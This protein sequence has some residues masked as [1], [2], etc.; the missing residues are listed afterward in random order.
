MSITL[1]KPLCHVKSCSLICILAVE[2]GE[3]TT[4]CCILPE[5][6]TSQCIFYPIK[7]EEREVLV[8]SAGTSR[9]PEGSHDAN[10][11]ESQTADCD[12]RK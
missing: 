7:E 12:I 10:Q 1:G 8:E 9:N 6:N 11:T 3:R 2:V 5:F 4:D